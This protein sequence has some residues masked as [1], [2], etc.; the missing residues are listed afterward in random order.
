MHPY[1]IAPRDGQWQSPPWG[2][3]YCPGPGKIRRKVCLLTTDPG[4]PR[5]L[6]M[7]G[8]WVLDSWWQHQQGALQGIRVYR[9][10]QGQPVR[11]KTKMC[12]SLRRHACLFQGQTSWHIYIRSQSWP[13]FRCTQTWPVSVHGTWK[14]NFPCSYGFKYTVRTSQTE[15]TKDVKKKGR[16]WVGTGWV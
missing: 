6:L 3:G 5:A 8:A 13:T 10:A 2:P 16:G 4:A 7:S 9:S 15:E 11:T 1:E 14:H 12:F